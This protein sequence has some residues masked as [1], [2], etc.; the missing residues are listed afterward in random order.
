SPSRSAP[1][2]TPFPAG[3]PLAPIRHRA[4]AC[5]APLPHPRPRS[6][7]PSPLTTAPAPAPSSPRSANARRSCCPPTRPRVRRPPA[8]ASLEAWIRRCTLQQVSSHLPFA[9]RSIRR[10]RPPKPPTAARPPFCSPCPPPRPSRPRPRCPPHAEGSATTSRRPRGDPPPP[11]SREAPPS[12]PERTGTDTPT[13]SRRHAATPPSRARRSASAVLPRPP[14]RRLPGP[15]HPRPARRSWPCCCA[16]LPTSPGDARRSRPGRRAFAA[17]GTR[18]RH[19]RRRPLPGAPACAIPPRLPLRRLPGP[20]HPR[21][22]R[23]SWPCRR[24]LLSPSPATLASPVAPRPRRR[25]RHLPGGPAPRSAPAPLPI[26]RCA[27]ASNRLPLAARVAL[28]SF[29]VSSICYL[30]SPKL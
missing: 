3:R 23:R 27:F 6:P 21:P 30:W 15:P 1:R 20:P 13:R 10:G 9:G 14:L 2:S 5:P 8:A 28:L 18:H 17:P 26:H 22:A 25:R 4:L 29:W 7:L 12:S 24:A 11:T 19:R 16:L